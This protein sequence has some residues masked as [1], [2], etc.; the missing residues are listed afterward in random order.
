MAVPLLW[1]GR[2]NEAVTLSQSL[3]EL[4]PRPGGARTQDGVITPVADARRLNDHQS[5]EG[6]VTEDTKIIRIPYSRTLHAPRTD[7]CER[8]TA[9]MI[10]QG[11][12]LVS[13]EQR[14]GVLGYGAH[15]RL[16]FSRAEER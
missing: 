15:T 2:R 16:T 14:K 11:W 12:T 5:F 4:V 8:V 7:E 6:H 3:E 13:W 9:E 1:Y 10:R